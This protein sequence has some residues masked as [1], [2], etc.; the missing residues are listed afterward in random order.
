VTFINC[1]FV[2]NETED[3]RKL[4]SHALADRSVQFT[5]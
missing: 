5:A 1:H 3:T 2:M 4:A